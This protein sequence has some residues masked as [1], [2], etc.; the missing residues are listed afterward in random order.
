MVSTSQDIGEEKQ[1][2]KF[3]SSTMNTFAVNKHLKRV[4]SAGRDGVRIVSLRDFKE[5]KEDFVPR[6]DLENGEVTS[7]A[8][9]PDG[10]ILTV[11]TVHGNVYNFLAKMSV[12]N[13]RYGTSVA[14]LSSLK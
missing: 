7:L 3:H 2:G 10:Q 13:A 4:A 12:L 11:A 6:E 5:V 1:S 14:Y 8:W 9:S